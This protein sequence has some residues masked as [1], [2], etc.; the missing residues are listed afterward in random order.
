MA[1]GLIYGVLL[2]GEGGGKTL[3]WTGVKSWK[4]EKGELWLHLD[5]SVYEVKEWLFH[6]SALDVSV[7]ETLLSSESR[8]RF[9]LLDS[10]VLMAWR[11]V[12]LN[13]DAERDDMVAIR[14]WREEGRLITT[15]QRD[16]MSINEVVNALAKGRGPKTI[17]ELLV[18]MAD[19]MVWK[20]GELVDGFDEDM[21]E[22]ESRVIENVNFSLKSELSVLRREV[23]SLRRYIG[24]QREA[25]MRFSVEKL[26]WLEQ[27]DRILLRE[28]VD[29]VTRALEEL[30]VLRERA[31]VTQ[32]E[33]Q[34]RIS[35]ELN[36]RMYVLSIITAIFLPL[37]FLTGLLG[38]N[39][40]GIPG[41]D[42]P[43]AFRYFLLGLVIIIVLQ[44]ILFK[45]RKWF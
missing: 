23:I 11:G 5:Y 27:N 31:S 8:P 30:E 26:N 14:M 37:G 41:A 38:I 2:D 3:D 4:P 6:E 18:D 39:V 16:L 13:P 42:N 19:K 15:L 9:S 17:G 40:G 24:P 36:N 10:G 28:V 1:N 29:R 32:E 22:L 44:L 20:I 21:S 12:N 34:N 33:L 7:A 25:L 45:W 43:S 35:E